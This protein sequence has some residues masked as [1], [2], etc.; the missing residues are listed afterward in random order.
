MQAEVRVHGGRVDINADN[1]RLIED[2]DEVTAH[3]MD[4][5]YTH[6]VRTKGPLPNPDQAG[7]PAG[8]PGAGAAPGVPGGPAAYGVGAAPSMGG[9]GGFAASSGPAAG[10]MS[11]FGPSAG[12]AAPQ[13]G[14]GAGAPAGGVDTAQ[15]QG[16]VEE[17]I[18]ATSK[19]EETGAFVGDIVAHLAPQGVP[20][21]QVRK[22]LEELIL[23]GIAYQTTDE[24]HYATTG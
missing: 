17:A 22:V 1:V 3:F 7:G 12:G 24:E 6:L 9:G 20:E 14:G 10:G 15:L 23:D 19:D 8:A 21:A 11:G 5:I 13:F 16:K 2:F 18:K 4:A